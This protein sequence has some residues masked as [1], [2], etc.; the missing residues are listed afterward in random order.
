M[1]AVFVP[2]RSG[3]DATHAQHE[4]N[5][6]DRS[7]FDFA[8]IRCLA[9]SPLSRNHRVVDGKKR[10]HGAIVAPADPR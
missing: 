2:S 1:L 6:Y 8:D 3:I 9:Y 10:A 4:I 7:M 5:R